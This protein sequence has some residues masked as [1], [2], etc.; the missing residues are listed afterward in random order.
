MFMAIVEASAVSDALHRHQATTND[1]QKLKT[2]PV[3]LSYLPLPF[4]PGCAQKS[5]LDRTLVA[6]LS[7]RIQAI[8]LPALL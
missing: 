7:L 5:A 6:R 3:C 8:L 1:T 4:L 2:I